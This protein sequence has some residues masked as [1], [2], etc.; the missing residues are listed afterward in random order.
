MVG[1]R[2]LF[3]GPYGGGSAGAAGSNPAT[4]LWG[5]GNR[6]GNTS[7]GSMGMGTIPAV[8]GANVMTF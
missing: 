2:R 5:G 4:P 6:G 8:G 7:A 3:A 1:A